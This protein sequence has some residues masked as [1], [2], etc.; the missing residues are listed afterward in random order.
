VLRTGNTERVR[1]LATGNV[2]IGT[3]SPASPLTVAGTIQ[4][5]SGGVKFPDGTTQTTAAPA[6]VTAVT[7]S[8]PLASSGGPTPNLT[9]GTVPV[10]NGGTGLTAAGA[11]GNYLRSD[12]TV[13]TSAALQAGDLPAGSAN[14][15]QNTTSPQAGASFN[16]AGSGTVGGNL[17]LP[18]TTATAGIIRSG[19]NTLLHTF[20]ASNLFVGV[21]AGNLTTSSLGGFGGNTGLGAAALSAN[22]TGSGNTA[23]GVNA[24]LNNTTG[25]NNTA[26]GAFAL[27][28]NSTGGSNTASGANA[29]SFNTTGGGNTATGSLALQ[30]NTTGGANTASGNNALFNNTTGS[31][32][33]ASGNNALGNNST[34]SNNTA[35]GSGADVG[36]GALTN[37]TAIGA[38]A[39]VGQSNAV[40]LG[41][42]GGN[43]VSVGVG[44]TTPQSTLQVVGNYIQFP[45]ISGSAPPGTDCTTAAQAGRVVVRTDGGTNLYVC[46]GTA[47]WVGK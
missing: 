5:T 3:A 19:A 7:A 20:G 41:G 28:A 15:V 43:A 46:T 1:V 24:L 47:G 38:N 12:G 21:G 39:V 11:A 25:P 29:L 4:T 17:T 23:S 6:G 9:L 37:A 8:A 22:T 16:I 10:A 33:T 45:T 40:V 42:T 18:P 30:A 35:V 27:Q 32:N 34:G 2:G 44:T 31:N 26:S 14:Y 36:S 13:W